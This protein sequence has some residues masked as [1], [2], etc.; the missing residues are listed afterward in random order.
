MNN[1]IKLFIFPLIIFLISPCK[2]IKAQA[3]KIRGLIIDSNTKEALPFVN[4]SFKGTSIGTTTD[5]DG[6]YFLETR[7]AGDSISISSIGYIQQTIPIKKG[8]FQTIN[9]NLYSQTIDLSEIIITPGENPAHTLLKKVIKRKKINNP[10]RY[11][12]FQYESYTKME[13]DINNFKNSFKSKKLLKKFQFIFNYVDTS[14]VTGKAYLPVLI[15]ESISDY[16]YQ[17]NPKKEKE[18]IKASKVS[19]VDSNE[20]IAQFTGQLHQN[21]NVYDNY[22]DLFDIGFHSPIADGGLRTYKYYLIDSAFR[23]KKW[24]Y[25][26]TFKPKR[27]EVP[28]FTGDFW[29][30]DSTYA[31]ESIKMRINKDVNINWVQDLVSETKFRQIND[32]IW[33]PDNKSLFIDFMLTKNDSTKQMG[34]FGRKNIA[35]RKVILNQPIKEKVLKLDNDVVVEEAALVRDNDYWNNSRPYKLSSRESK[36]YEMVDSI[37]NVPIYKNI[38]DV[39]KTF[40]TGYYIKGK[41]EY[42]PYYK[43]ISSNE[44]EGNRFMFGGRTTEE[45]NENLRINAHLAY[46]TKDKKLKYGLGA[47]YMLNKQKRETVEVQYR[48]DIEQLGKGP[49]TITE[50]NMLASLL[51]RNPNNKLTMAT[52]AS[53][54]YE[55]TWKQGFSNKISFRH[56]IITPSSYI[57]FNGAGENANKTFKNIKTSEIELNTRWTKN[58]RF[59]R[60]NFNRAS[61]GSEY[62]IVNLYLTLM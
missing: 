43:L 22:I 49:N 61:L 32:S 3:T 51:K 57:Q 40:V 24:C 59:I 54:M 6:N 36:I 2:D 53:F 35:Y 46:G 7:Q 60:G 42:G 8:E 23:E 37:Q 19:G 58:E 9:I 10:D 55:K 14:V 17:K 56:K 48:H 11:E 33:F 34:F 18:V 15:S 30:A 41:F 29:V 25:H 39:I 4:I 13:L 38:V 12:S 21:I 52:E 27:K 5:F 31:I 28:A 26:I 16:Y 20:S 45:F 47:L 44:I 1:Y 62:P 50:G